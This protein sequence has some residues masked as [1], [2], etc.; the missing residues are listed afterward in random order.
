MNE[1]ILQDEFRA[2]LEAAKNLSSI[3]KI[4][5][6]KMSKEAISRYG[7]LKLAHPEIAIKAIAA[8]AQAVHSGMDETITDEQFKTLLKQIRK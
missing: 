1:E 4:A 2:R 7:S 8:I 5:K 6:Q 3:E